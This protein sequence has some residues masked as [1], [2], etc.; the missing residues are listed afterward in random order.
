[1][2]KRSKYRPRHVL[3][4]PV[5]YVVEG[6]KPVSQHDDYLIDLR[7]KNHGAMAALTQGKA[8]HEDMRTMTAMTN[9]TV[10]LWSLGFGKEYSDDV[11][12][13]R[14]ALM[15]IAERGREN[16]HFV[17]RAGEMA[18]LNMLLE[19]HDAQLDI[20]SIKDMEKAVAVVH[21]AAREGKFERLAG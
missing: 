16:Q 15:C 9:V 3:V 2:K 4:N 6:L 19:L 13:G 14:I 20:I 12:A 10:A 11:T 1:M 17:M 5:G 7:I 21:K 8:T 18:A